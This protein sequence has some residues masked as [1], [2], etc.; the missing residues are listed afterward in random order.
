MAPEIEYFTVFCITDNA[1]REVRIVEK[2]K[3]TP[4]PREK[5][6]RRL[7]AAE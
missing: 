1:K 5:K 2:A 4:K 3:A 6:I 7:Q